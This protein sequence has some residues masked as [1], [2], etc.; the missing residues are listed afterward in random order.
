MFGGIVIHGDKI[1]KTLGFP[2]ANLNIEKK[3]CKLSA[4]VYAVEATLDRKKYQGALAIQEKKWKVEVYLLDYVGED[5]YGKYIEVDPV[6]KVGEMEGF[7]SEEELV[8]KIQGDVAKVK[9]IWET[10]T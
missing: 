6:Q 3:D 4:G 8:E 9:K 2:T 7:D 1:G 5:F 10:M